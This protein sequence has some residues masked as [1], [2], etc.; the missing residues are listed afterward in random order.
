MCFGRM[1]FVEKII[2]CLGDVVSFDNTYATNKYS[3]IFAP[4]TGVNHH[5]Q[6]VTFGALFLSDERIDSFVWLFEKILEQWRDVNQ[7]L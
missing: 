5:R 3:M 2:P 1:E 4:F 6:C 7:S